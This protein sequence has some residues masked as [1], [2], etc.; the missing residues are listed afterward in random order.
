MVP[1]I[2][3]DGQGADVTNSA[4]EAC[5]QCRIKIKS[6]IMVL[7]SLECRFKF[8]LQ[9]IQFTNHN[10]YFVRCIVVYVIKNI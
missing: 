1:A 3:V 7:F 5:N 10:E 8:Y 4:L 2:D 6:F 9:C